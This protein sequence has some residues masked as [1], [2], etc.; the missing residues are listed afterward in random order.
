MN[1]L[2][3]KS[4]QIIP[5]SYTLFIMCVTA[6]WTHSPPA[7]TSSIGMPSGP[8]LLLFLVTM[9]LLII[10]SVVKPSSKFYSSSI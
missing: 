8:G 9:R 7:F 3:T 4:P 1:S 10:S 5:H 6:T 2:S